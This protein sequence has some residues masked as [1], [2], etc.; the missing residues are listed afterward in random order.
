[1]NQ[2]IIRRSL[3]VFSAI[4]KSF[5][6]ILPAISQ[7]ITVTAATRRSFVS[8]R[9]QR[10][11]AEQCYAIRQQPLLPVSWVLHRHLGW[12]HYEVLL[13]K[14]FLWS[15]DILECH[16]KNFKEGLAEVVAF[17]SR[18]YQLNNYFDGESERAVSLW[19][20]LKRLVIIL[21]QLQRLCGA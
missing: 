13:T 4:S 20:F 19:L 3:K 11:S 12:R 10:R 9:A 5:V 1:M 14:C 16:I 15:P 18:N 7:D 21:C 6:M 8:V 2:V 17:H